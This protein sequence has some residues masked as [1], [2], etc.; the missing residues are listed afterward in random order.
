MHPDGYRGV[1]LTAPVLPGLTGRISVDSGRSPFGKLI[2]LPGA[3]RGIDVESG[4]VGLICGSIGING[5]V[6]GE[7]DAVG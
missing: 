2:A 1:L 3:A 5:D 4:C 6:S 7:R